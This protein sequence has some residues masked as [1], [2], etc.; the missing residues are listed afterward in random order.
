M[1]D[2]RAIH[3]DT[4][5][6]FK[7]FLDCIKDDPRLRGRV[8]DVGCGER[9]SV[10]T[11]GALFPVYQ[12]AASLDGL[13]PFPGVASHPW[14]EHA[15]VGEAEKVDLPREAYDASLAINVPEHIADPVPFLRAIACTLKPGGVLY[16]ITPHARHP[17]A[18]SVRLIQ[19]IN[20]KRRMAAGNAE[21]N[22]YPA[23]YR[24]NSRA[25][26]TRAGEAAGY[27]AAR[28]YYH[29][30]THWRTYLPTVLRPAGWFYDATLGI[31]VMS[32]AQQFM[33]MLEKPGNGAGT[34]LPPR[35]SKVF[36][37]APVA[38]AARTCPAPS[39]QQS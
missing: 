13:D 38:P 32:A 28:V 19:A 31:H 15:W 3:A 2:H 16:A 1:H 37:T 11:V 12:L 14:M 34:H 9:P 4:D 23:Y 6:S 29:P 18:W 25:A 24:L 27:A 30:H 5:A 8:L 26:V 35:T 7:F 21:F 22:D 39:L 17:F 36:H 20:L 10:I 33:F